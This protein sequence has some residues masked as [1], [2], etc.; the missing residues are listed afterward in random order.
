MRKKMWGENVRKY[1]ENMPDNL[2]KICKKKWQKNI[3]TSTQS[4]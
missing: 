3:Q 2:Q 1:V 4:L